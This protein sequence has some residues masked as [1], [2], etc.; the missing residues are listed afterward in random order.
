MSIETL[1]APKGA[2]KKAKRLGRGPGS[3]TGKTAGKGHKGQ[4]ARKSG[5]TGIGFEGGQ[6]PL[7]RRLPKRGFK[8]YPFKEQYNIINVNILNKFDENAEIKVENFKSS[9][10]LNYDKLPIKIL[11]NG[12]LKKKLTVHAHKFSKSSIEKIEKAGGK[13]IVIS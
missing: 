7:Y 6:T 13:A 1:R 11:G 2:N 12:E 9:G 8:N 10:L 3:G 4:N 5:G